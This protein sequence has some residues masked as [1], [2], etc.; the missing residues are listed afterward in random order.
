MYSA[1][2]S[3]RFV[4]APSARPVKLDASLGFINDE[5]AHPNIQLSAGSKKSKGAIVVGAKPTAFLDAPLLPPWLVARPK[6]G[7]R[8][9]RERSQPLNSVPPPP[10]RSTAIQNCQAPK[11]KAFDAGEITLNPPW[12]VKD[13]VEVML[14][15]GAGDR[16]EDL[17]EMPL[18][19]PLF[20]WVAL[21]SK[22]LSGDAPNSFP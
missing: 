14:R 10:R 17:S 13:F 18:A 3:P 7:R 6:V 1:R 9:P 4:E 5:N 21:S 11:G 2:S 20:R 8:S 22:I 15:F 12:T 19:D 16:E